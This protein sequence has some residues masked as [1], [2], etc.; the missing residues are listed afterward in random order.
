MPQKI[1]SM[2]EVVCRTTAGIHQTAKLFKKFLCIVF[3]FV[4]VTNTQQSAGLFALILYEMLKVDSNET[5]SV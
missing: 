3:E 5:P 2:I 4:A 1:L